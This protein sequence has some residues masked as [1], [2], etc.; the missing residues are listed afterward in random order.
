MS[1]PPAAPLFELTVVG[2]LGPVLEAALL[3][4]VCHGVQRQTVV[5]LGTS[6]L[7]LVEVLDHLGRRHLR[8]AGITELG[9]AG[10]DRP[11]PPVPGEAAAADHAPS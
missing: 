9:A 2:D 3:P 7:D 8:V 1:S 6:G 5:R 4:C 11:R 10:G